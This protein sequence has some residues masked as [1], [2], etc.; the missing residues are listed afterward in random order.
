[1]LV[2]AGLVLLALL[3]GQSG[4]AELGEI[5]LLHRTGD[6][7]LGT[8]GVF[9]P[10]KEDQTVFP[11]GSTL[12]AGDSLDAAGLDAALKAPAASQAA[13][14]AAPGR[15]VVLSP[16]ASAR[17]T[18]GEGGAPALT[19]TGAVTVLIAAEDEKTPAELILNGHKLSGTQAVLFY[20]G[21]KSPTELSVVMGQVTADVLPPE[22]PAAAAPAAGSDAAPAP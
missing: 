14:L 9:S 19:L 7:A 20:N 16:G 18:T 17:F 21:W 11:A 10:V 1:M 2:L 6:L 4:A 5:G 22:K 15:V 3:P 13:L 12:R 8:G